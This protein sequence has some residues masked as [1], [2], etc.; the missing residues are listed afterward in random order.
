GGVQSAVILGVPGTIS[1]TWQQAGRAGRGAEDSLAILVAYDTAINQYLMHHP[2]YFFAKDS[3]QVL[4]A[5]RNRHILASQLACACYELPLSL[6]ELP[7]FVAGKVRGHLPTRDIEALVKRHHAELR[8]QVAEGFRKPKEDLGGALELPERKPARPILADEADEAVAEAE[9]LLE[10]MAEEGLVRRSGG[11]YYYAEV[12]KPA[13]RVSIRAITTHNYTIV[14]ITDP[15]QEV[16]LGEIDQL[17]AY[18][19]LHPGAIYFHAGEQYYVEKLDRERKRAEIRRVE[20]DYYT[21]PHGGRGVS[22]IQS[23]EER[24]KFPGG[25]VWLGDV[26]CHFNTECYDKIKL[27]SREPFER[28]PVNLPPQVLE[29]TAYWVNPNEKTTDRI[30]QYGRNPQ[31]GCYGLG[32]ALMVVTA[33]FASC[34]PLDIRTSEAPRQEC[35]RWGC[36]EFSCFI[37]DNHQGGLG[38]AELAFSRIEEVL[39]T[40]LSLIA[41]C[42]CEEGCPFCVGFYLRP[43]IRH[44]PENSEGWI[45][46]K[47][48]ALM[49]LYDVLGLQPYQPKPLSDR[50]PSWRQR[51]TVHPCIEPEEVANKPSK[52]PADLPE[53]IKG[54]ILRRLGKRGKR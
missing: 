34:D 46:D 35:E 54:Q 39:E 44:D 1:A 2:A 5:P 4:I 30:R 17:S 47:E 27:W 20:V 45:P 33:L 48:V 24:A 28:C 21:A 36:N 29:T 41:E 38:F 7:H 15:D 32:Q 10:M 16:I 42:P 49:I 40:T 13:Y 14:D 9:T 11:R 6:E 23:V 26:T 19:I 52:T 18:P 51:V 22:L 37:F 53:H 31:T 43:L 50:S 12:T 8:A 25:E 3:E